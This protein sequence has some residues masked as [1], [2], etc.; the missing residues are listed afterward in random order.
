MRFSLLF[1]CQFTTFSINH[2]MY[3]N[4]SVQMLSQNM[5]WFYN[6]Y[7]S[8]VILQ[9]VGNNHITQ[10][11]FYMDKVVI[12]SSSILNTSLQFVC[13]YSN[14]S[15]YRN[16]SKPTEANALV[17]VLRYVKWQKMVLFHDSQS[18]KYKIVIC[19]STAYIALTVNKYF[20]GS[21]FHRR[22]MYV[23][24]ISPEVHLITTNIYSS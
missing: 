2:N 24:I 14:T 19:Y 12:H 16:H 3:W 9:N 10:I 22:S 23:S 15:T 7:S 20:C 5:S 6:D 4:F 1:I 17:S 13:K 21:A 18:G 8:K 11:N